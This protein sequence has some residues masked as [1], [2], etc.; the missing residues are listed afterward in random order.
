MQR[1]AI[2]IAQ[3]LFMLAHQPLQRGLPNGIVAAVIIHRDCDTS[4]LLVIELMESTGV[5]YR[6]QHCL[7]V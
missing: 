6:Q 3:S 1:G 4:P 2:R 5:P 7:T